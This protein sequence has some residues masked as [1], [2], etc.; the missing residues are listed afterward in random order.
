MEQNER[1][2]KQPGEAEAPIQL[3]LN[4]VQPESVRLSRVFWNMKQR[5]RLFAWILV[6]CMIVGAC[7]P[8]IL[9]PLLKQDL[10]VAS[11]VSGV[12]WLVRVV[13]LPSVTG[14]SSV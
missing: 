1:I 5:R 2:L 8:L 6:L 12:C 14:V 3:V 13:I 9:Y 10:T 4:D 7:A 11:V